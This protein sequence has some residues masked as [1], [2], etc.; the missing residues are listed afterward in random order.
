MHLL[1]Y[2][3]THSLWMKVMII[4]LSFSHPG[5]RHKTRRT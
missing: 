4:D 3:N 1:P 2:Y 5:L